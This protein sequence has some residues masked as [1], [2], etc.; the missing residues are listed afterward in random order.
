MRRTEARGPDGGHGGHKEGPGGV[1]VCR[2]LDDAAVVSGRHH[3]VQALHVADISSIGDEAVRWDDP[4]AGLVGVVVVMVVKVVP[5]T[6]LL[7]AAPALSFTDG[8][9]LLWVI[10][11]VLYKQ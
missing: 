4:E 2:V 11:V 3:S 10:I 1:G 5:L 7:R 6:V 9:L 8:L